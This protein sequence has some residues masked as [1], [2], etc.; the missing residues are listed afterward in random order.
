MTK[1]IS[2]NNKKTKHG[3]TRKKHKVTIINST[4]QN[5]LQY[6]EARTC[7]PLNVFYWH[8]TLRFYQK[9]HTLHANKYI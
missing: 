5:L 6:L 8:P 9:T 2:E 7:K 3:Q 4:A 1:Q